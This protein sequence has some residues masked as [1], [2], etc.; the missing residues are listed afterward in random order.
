MTF[1][2]FIPPD[3]FKTTMSFTFTKVEFRKMNKRQKITKLSG[4]VT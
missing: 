1:N 3:H 2:N 4:F